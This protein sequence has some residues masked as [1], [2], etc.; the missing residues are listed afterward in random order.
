MYYVIEQNTH[1]DEKTISAVIFKSHIL[2]RFT[3]YNIQ[4]CHVNC[5]F[6][7]TYR[8]IQ[9]GIRNPYKSI[10]NLIIAVEL[11]SKWR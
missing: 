5:V 4:L 3:Y 10:A 7:Y 2:Y 1:F 8:V 6:A 9:F 11:L